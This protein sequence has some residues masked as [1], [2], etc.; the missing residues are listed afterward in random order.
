MVLAK[1]DCRFP[2]FSPI[3][4]THCAYRLRARII[5]LLSQIQLRMSPSVD[6]CFSNYGIFHFKTIK[7]FFSKGKSSSNSCDPHVLPPQRHPFPPPPRTSSC[8]RVRPAIVIGFALAPGFLAAIPLW[9]SRVRTLR[10]VRLHA[11]M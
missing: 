10:D 5:R 3:A 8:A 11:P 2:S 7:Y 4:E 1:V 9:P 6:S